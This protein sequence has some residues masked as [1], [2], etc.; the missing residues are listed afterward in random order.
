MALADDCFKVKILLVLVVA[1][2]T[3]KLILRHTIGFRDQLSLN[4]EHNLQFFALKSLC[5]FFLFLSDRL[6]QV[7]IYVWGFCVGPSFEI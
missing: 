7:L 2:I 3:A 5:F 1:P 6:R 4:S